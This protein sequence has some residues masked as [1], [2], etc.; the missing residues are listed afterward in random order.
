MPTGGSTARARVVPGRS[1]RLRLPRRPIFWRCADIF[2]NR[3]TDG[4]QGSELFGSSLETNPKGFL[5]EKDDLGKTIV[6]S[7][8]ALS[9]FPMPQN[10]Y[11]HVCD[12]TCLQGCKQGRCVPVP[13]AQTGKLAGGNAI[14]SSLLQLSCPYISKSNRF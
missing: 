14:W 9:K 4:Y 13:C 2:C 8:M 6:T 1:A 10:A 3:R 5:Y 12:V 7:V 11:A